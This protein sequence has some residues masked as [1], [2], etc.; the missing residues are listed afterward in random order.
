MLLAEAPAL[1]ETV[2]DSDT[3]LLPDSVVLGVLAGVPVAEAVGVPETVAVGV[4]GGEAELDHDVLPVLLAEAPRVTEAV[5]DCVSVLLP[6]SVEEG[7]L[8]A[9]PVPET[10][11]VPVAV[12]VTVGG[13]EEE[14]LSEVLAVLLAE[15]PSVREAVGDADTVL[16]ADRVVLGV[17]GPE[18]VAL[19]VGVP[20]VLAVAV[21]LGVAL[22]LAPR[23]RVA[24]GEAV[25]VLLA[26]SVE[27]GETEPVPVP[28]GLLLGVSEE[29]G[30]GLGAAER[31]A[32]GDSVPS[33]E[34]VAVG[35]RVAGGLLVA[36]ALPAEDGVSAGDTV[37]DRVEDC[38]QEPLAVSM[39][40]EEEEE[41][42][43]G[44]RVWEGAGVP[45]S[46]TGRAAP[47]WLGVPE[48]CRLAVHALW[49]GV[50]E[51]CLLG[52]AES[53]L[54]GVAVRGAPLR[55][56]LRWP[57]AEA[58]GE[59][60]AAGAGPGTP[61]LYSTPPPSATTISLLA[62]SAGLPLTG[63]GMGSF[64][65]CPPLLFSASRLPLTP[66]LPTPTTSCELQAEC[67]GVDSVKASPVVFRL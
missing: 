67:A 36:A 48:L 35:A 47:L 61:S 49:L 31:L 55:V 6:V 20:L 37:P 65:S 19:G 63:L 24:V 30:V 17:P 29:V 26:D 10:V 2:G 45:L 41:E 16:L 54:L 23:D 27:V 21:A 22:G 12:A 32:L 5:G 52:V 62:A 39:G 40:A 33:W 42:G 9:V 13:G 64:H 66:P 53:C 58:R 25:T 15:A 11:G 56:G 18:A 46:P 34:G 38:E 60:E 59:G 4:G 1:G 3:V 51:S 43:M 14:P 50:A 44:G 8:S 57:D 28:E 7:V